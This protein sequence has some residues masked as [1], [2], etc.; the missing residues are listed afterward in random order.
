[1]TGDF[2]RAYAAGVDQWRIWFTLLRFGEFV[3][4]HSAMLVY[5]IYLNKR[6][7]CLFKF[8]TLRGKVGGEGVELDIQEGRLSN[9][10]Y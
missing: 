2:I 1:M 5:H 6:L 3:K 9:F 8:W 10:P 7:G 4:Q